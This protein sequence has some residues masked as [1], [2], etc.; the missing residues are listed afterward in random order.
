M[1]V[2]MERDEMIITIINNYY[3]MSEV[4]RLGIG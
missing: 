3:E 1:L 4:V 2:G